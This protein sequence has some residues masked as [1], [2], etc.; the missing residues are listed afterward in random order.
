MTSTLLSLA[1]I[2]KRFG[3]L[4]A[5]NGVSLDIR[6]NEFFA[7]LGASGSGK[8]TLLRMLAGFD[9]PSSGHI[10]LD[11]HDISQV[12]PN[13]RP[14]NLMFQSYALFPHMTVAQNIAYG[15]EME[16]LPRTEINE[17]VD[18]MLS[19]IQLTH[20]AE[21]KPEQL[22]GG[23]RQRVALGRALVKRPRLLLLDEPL[24]A[25]DKKLR[26]EMQL[27][28]KHIQN[29][30]GITFIV[31]THDQEE[32]LVMA[33]RIAILKDGELLQCGSPHEIYEYPVNRF[34]AD[35]IGVM[36]FLPARVDAGALC[37]ANGSRISA[38]L[39]ADLKPGDNA[40][41]AVRPE[42]LRLGAADADNCLNGRISAMAYHGLDLHLHL[43]TPVSPHPLMVRLT[44]DV[45]EGHPFAVGE[46]VSVGWSARD[47]RV[48]TA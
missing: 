18:E 42:R 46:E 45:A 47:T 23:Q 32:A 29:K 43:E 4:R 36:N 14:V 5:V 30:F 35:F 16:K 28:L 24:G 21:R 3:E 33:D 40:L 38:S 8:T 20:L 9:M 6:E 31:V 34:A 13:H 2:E 19:T 26:G 17:R 7:L 41:A 12:P 27:E 37:T 48:F 15:L 22:S 1:N 10:L 39:P 11:G 25:L 44:A